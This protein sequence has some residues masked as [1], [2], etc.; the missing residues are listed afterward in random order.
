MADS[1]ALGTIG[2]LLGAA[3]IFVMMVGTMVVANHLTGRLQIDDGLP[4]VSLPL[5]AR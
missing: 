4:V 1:S 2:L 3:A 5:A